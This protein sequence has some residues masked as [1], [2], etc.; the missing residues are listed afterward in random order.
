MT[1]AGI[2]ARILVAASLALWAGATSAENPAAGFS[3]Q[4]LENIGNYVKAD[5]AKGLI[6]GA[7][8]AIVRHGQAVFQQTWGE[9]DPTTKA[10]M[11]AD[12]IF[13]IYS[14]SKPIT[15]VAA[16]M[17]VEEGRL[18]LDEPVANTSRNSPP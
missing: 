11:T 5:I 14:M 15:T 16:M 18:A 4:R 10:P 9:R 6:P 2:L 1:Q 7:V 8:L 12:S 3:Q 17:L 13:R